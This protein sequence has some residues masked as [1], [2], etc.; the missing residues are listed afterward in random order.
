[1]EKNQNI[2]EMLMEHLSHPAIDKTMLRNY[3]SRI[4][5]AETNFKWQRIWWIG[6]PWPEI[7]NIQTSFPVSEAYKIKSL[8]TPEVNSI[9]IFP[10]GIPFPEELQAV[11]KIPIVNPQIN[12]EKF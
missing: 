11:V 8:F 10:I 3:S 5:G 4:A 1:M 9:E 12:Q 2:E 7:L 6:I